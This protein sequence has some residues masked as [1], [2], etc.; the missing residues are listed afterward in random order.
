MVSQVVKRVSPKRAK[1]LNCTL[2]KDLFSSSTPVQSEDELSD[3]EEEMD[4][5][6]D[7]SYVPDPDEID[8]DEE[9]KF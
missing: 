7:P 2:L 4:E 9:F 5:D 1:Q 3:H 8:A 6:D